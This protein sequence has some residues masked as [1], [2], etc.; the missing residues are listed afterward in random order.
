[1]TI[2]TTT[3]EE[4]KQQLIENWDKFALNVKEFVKE[5]NNMGKL[6]LRNAVKCTFDLK[7]DDVDRYMNYDLE[8]LHHRHEIKA[9]ETINAIIAKVSAKVGE[10]KTCTK[11]GE[12]YHIEGELAKARLNIIRAGGYNVQRLHVRTLIK[13]IK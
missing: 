8:N 4:C 2:M 3:L 5:H 9:T 11:L 7:G 12:Y 6:E 10:V 13:V 1:M